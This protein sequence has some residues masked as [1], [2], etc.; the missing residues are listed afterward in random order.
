M[1]ISM[2]EAGLD[3]INNS[4][5]VYDLGTS[6]Y[7]GYSDCTM[8]ITYTATVNSSADMI[9][10]DDGNPNTVTLEW[11]RTNM[12]YYDTLED[13]CHFYAYGLDLLK[14][15]NDGKGNV[16]NVQ[17]KI[18]NNTDKYWVQAA[19]NEAEGV[20]Y[21]TDHVDAE[22]DATTFVPVSDTQKIIVKG[23]ED[24]EYV[25]TEIATDDKYL[26]LKDPITVKITTAETDMICAV[27][28]KPGLTATATVNG[29]PVAMT[30]DNGSVSAIV[31]FKVTN[32][33][34]PEMPKTGEQGTWLFAAGGVMLV[35][36][37]AGGIL[38]CIKRRRRQADEK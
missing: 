23:L 31:P 2:T 26:L 13:D 4:D 22:A 30:E 14:E 33:R 24:D 35:S 18:W 37:A 3:E 5:A 25:L 8:R 6:L 1:T 7:R 36:L 19:L 29:D 32:V 20:Y 34:A 27:C 10:G 11:R 38:I 15:F 16:A 9:Y 12:D 28:G 21:V 17:F